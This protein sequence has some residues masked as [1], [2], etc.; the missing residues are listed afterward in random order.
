MALRKINFIAKRG[1]NTTYGT[2]S[3]DG[4][5]QWR[6]LPPITLGALLI[7]IEC[8]TSLNPSIINHTLPDQ[9]SNLMVSKP[10][11]LCYDPFR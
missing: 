10:M 2:D 8:S 1:R 11:M 7:K 6:D 5:Q 3:R 4:T 9:I